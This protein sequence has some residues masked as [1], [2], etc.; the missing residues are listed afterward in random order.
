M[1]KAT[2]SILTDIK[3]NLGNFT[4]YSVDSDGVVVDTR[5]CPFPFFDDDETP[6]NEYYKVYNDGGNY[7][8][9]PYY[10]GVGKHKE[11]VSLMEKVFSYSVAPKSDTIT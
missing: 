5:D 8:A 11:K 7:V 6:K 4:G 2:V 10:K 1:S 3:D 9:T